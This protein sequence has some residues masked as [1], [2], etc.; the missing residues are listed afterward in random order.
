MKKVIRQDGKR[1]VFILEDDSEIPFPKKKEA[2]KVTPK[3]VEEVKTDKE[4]SKE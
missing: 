4:E 1:R 2:K 3:K